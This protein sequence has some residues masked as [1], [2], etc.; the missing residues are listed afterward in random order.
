MNSPID[1]KYIKQA[2]YRYGSLNKKNNED[3]VG[4]LIVLPLTPA[5]LAIKKLPALANLYMS[6]STR[7]ID[8]S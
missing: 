6:L 8:D 2:K 3:N 1:R 7:N 4:P 5:E